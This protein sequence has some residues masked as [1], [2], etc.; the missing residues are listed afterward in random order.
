MKKTYIAPQAQE[1]NTTSAS[2]LTISDLTAA[3]TQTS[4]T[5]DAKEGQV[6]FDDDDDM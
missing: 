5:M 2:L 3:P 6:N 1:I 4:A